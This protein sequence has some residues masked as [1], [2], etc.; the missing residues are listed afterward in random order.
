MKKKITLLLTFI[1]LFCISCEDDSSETD[2]E[3]PDWTETQHKGKD[4]IDLGLPSGTLWATTDVCAETQDGEISYFFSWGETAPKTSYTE[5]TY[6]HTAGA[7]NMLT[8]YCV[9]PSFGNNGFTDGLAELQSSDDVANILWGGSWFIPAW[10]EWE[11]LYNNCDWETIES[12]GELAFVATSKINGKKISFSTKGAM[13]GQKLLYEGKGAFYWSSTLITD[14]CM[15]AYGISMEPST[16]YKKDGKRPIGHCVRAVVSGKRIASEAI[17]LGLPSGIKWASAN[18][19]AKTPEQAGYLYAWGETITKES[20][21]FTNYKH[22]N[23]TPQ[24]L[25]KYCTDGK[26]QLETEDDAAVQ[27]WGNGWRMPTF[28]EIQE[29]MDNC[30]WILGTIGEQKGYT[31]TG[32]NGKSIFLPLAGTKWQTGMEFQNQRGFYWSSTLDNAGNKWAEGLFI[33]SESVLEGNQFTRASGRTIRP[34]HD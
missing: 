26:T 7:E 4:F 8:K 32:K 29:L 30:T 5:A 20:Y 9:N 3:E 33:N 6:K 2:P 11:E 25:T 12:N 23:G 13:Q 18:I 1:S 19:G 34:V 21:D 31:V 17:D 14:D 22:C 15:Y 16:I 27:L 24:T 10:E 28:K